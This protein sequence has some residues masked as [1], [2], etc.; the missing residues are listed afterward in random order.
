MIPKIPKVKAPHITKVRPPTEPYEF[1]RARQR[2]QQKDMK[3]Y[4]RG[5]VIWRS[6]LLVPKSQFAYFKQVVRGR[7]YKQIPIGF[8]KIKGQGTYVSPKCELC[9]Y[10]EKKCTCLDSL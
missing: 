9:G 5:R 1:H 4:L 2:A 8:T 3:E 6:N 10:K 7:G